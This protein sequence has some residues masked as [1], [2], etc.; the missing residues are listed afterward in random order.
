MTEAAADYLKKP[1]GRLL[2]P[3]DDGT[4]RA[5]IIEFPGCFAVGKNAAEAVENL[6]NAASSWLE[7]TLAKG[8][9]VPEPMEEADYSGKLL[10]RLPKSLHKHATY[11][12]NR[13]GVS[14]N[15]FIVSSIAEQVGGY[16]VSIF[17][18]ARGALTFTLKVGTGKSH[19]MLTQA[20]QKEVF[21]TPEAPL[22][23]ADL[24]GALNAGD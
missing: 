15:Q 9:S 16:R 22:A 5:E 12:A 7:S 8:R 19:N 14:L 24:S 23:L 1:Y 4:Y 3:E 10:V 17:N 11:A 20:F 13:E 6:E 2:V 18:T 21:F